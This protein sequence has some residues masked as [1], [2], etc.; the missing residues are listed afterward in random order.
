MRAINQI[1]I[2]CSDTP[3]GMDIG[4]E[5][6]RR[7]HV[8]ENGWADIGYHH[9]IRRSGQI[10]PGRPVDKAGA[11]AAGH[12][13]TSIGICL[14]GGKHGSNF[15]RQQMRTLDDLVQ[16]LTALYPDAAVCGHNDLTSAK[17]CPQFNVRAWWNA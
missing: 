16:S 14:V 4:V 9:V 3:P 2:H 17:S 1:V 11:H 13:A 15:T 12:N 8:D 7:W 5:E 10:E 6:I